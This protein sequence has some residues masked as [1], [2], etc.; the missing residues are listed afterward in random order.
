S[1]VCFLL[2]LRPSSRSSL[3]PYT[4]LFRSK[5]I[6]TR[7]NSLLDMYSSGAFYTA[8]AWESNINSSLTA[9][10]QDDLGS[11]QSTDPASSNKK[12]IYQMYFDTDEVDDWMN[13]SVENNGEIFDDKRDGTDGPEEAKWA[14][15]EWNIFSNGTDIGVTSLPTVA[16]A[17]I[18]YKS[19]IG[20]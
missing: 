17:D 20:S 11:T 19:S 18:T 3:F 16:D 13:R 7:L 10:F 6:F 1:C 8:S 15:M 9:N 14:N 4:T 12:T 5:V 2:I